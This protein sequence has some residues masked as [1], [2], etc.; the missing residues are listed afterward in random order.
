MRAALRGRYQVGVAFLQAFARLLRPGQRPLDRL[1]PAL[2][3][4]AK[5]IARDTFKPLHGIEQVVPGTAL[6][7]PLVLVAVQPVI[8]TDC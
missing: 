4:P 2:E 5:R 8:E 7:A 3:V 6:V 1:L